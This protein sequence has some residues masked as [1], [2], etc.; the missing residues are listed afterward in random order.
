MRILLT[1]ALVLS[2]VAACNARP[3]YVPKNGDIVFHTSRSAQSLAVQ[4]ATHSEY[5]HMGVV[6][7]EDGKSFVFEAVQPVKLTPLPEWVK[8]GE[9]G[10]FVAK[11][12][13]NADDLLT[14]QSLKKLKAEG[15]QL[16]GKSYDLYFEWSDDRIYCSELVWKMYKRALGVEIGHTQ[17]LE[18]FDLSDPVVQGKIRERWKGPPPKDEIVISPAEMFKSE[19]L[20]MVH[21]Q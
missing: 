3:A 18:D 10:H 2:S 15:R 17:R 9:S 6:Y 19:L 11:R 13:R 21:E 12:L 5:S 16:R 20:V 7:V 8:R 4:R 1:I 14:P